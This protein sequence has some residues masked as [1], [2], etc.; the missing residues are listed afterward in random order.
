M[1]LKEFFKPTKYTIIIFIILIIIFLLILISTNI[2]MFPCKTQ[3]VVPNPPEPEDNL[4]G[5]SAGLGSSQEF[6]PLGY[7]IMIIVIIVLPYVIS[8]IINSLIKR[9]KFRG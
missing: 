4:C 3:S 8:C 6:T 2:R 7:L 9:N 5:F 1:G